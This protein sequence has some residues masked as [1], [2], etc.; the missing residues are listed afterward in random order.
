MTWKKERENCKKKERRGYKIQGRSNV[1]K[2]KLGKNIILLFIKYSL[3]VDRMF[4]I[5]ITLSIF[6]ICFLFLSIKSI[7]NNLIDLFYKFSVNQ[8]SYF[9]FLSKV[10][11]RL[12]KSFLYCAN[13]IYTDRLTILLRN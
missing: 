9:I 11:Q 3:I 13:F 2:N 6:F 7:I 10:N 12:I 4:K 8:L 5:N 1:K